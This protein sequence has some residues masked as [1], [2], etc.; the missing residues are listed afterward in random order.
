MTNEI[1]PASLPQHGASASFSQERIDLIKRTYC[2]G[3]TNDELELFIAVCNRTGLSPE[4]RQVFAVKRWDS[5]EKR[6]IMSIQ[7]SIDGFRLTAER[8]GKYA[9]QLGPQWCDETGEW[10]DVWLKK[11]HPSAARVAVLRSDFKEPLWAV[12]RLDSYIQTKQDGHPSAMWAKMSDLMLAKCAESLALRKAF[13]AELSGL[14]SQEEMAQA[15]IDVEHEAPKQLVKDIGAERDK[16][17]NAKDKADIDWLKAQPD[18]QLMDQ[19]EVK[20]VAL[21][22]HGKNVFGLRAAIS[23]LEEQQAKLDHAK[24]MQVAA[25]EAALTQ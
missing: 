12:A 14:Y 25:Q 7:V 4:A 5:K 15:T 11:G 22:L 24:T 19:L 16:I 10:S 18:V 1:V 13:P 17:F 3:A 8:S 6:E 20:T 9:G 21:E 23:R 2:K